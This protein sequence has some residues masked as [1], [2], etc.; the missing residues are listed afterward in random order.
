[1]RC[2]RNVH[3]AA[4]VFHQAATFAHDKQVD[5][6][7]IEYTRPLHR[8]RIIRKTP[9]H[10][11]LQNMENLLASC[12]KMKITPEPVRD[13]AHLQPKVLFSENQ[14]D[15]VN[16]A[17][18]EKTM[19]DVLCRDKPFPI[20]PAVVGLVGAFSLP[21]PPSFSRVIQLGTS[22]KL[23]QGSDKCVLESDLSQLPPDFEADSPVS[24]WE[25]WRRRVLK[26]SG[27]F[28]CSIGTQTSPR[29]RLQ[30]TGVDNWTQTS[31]SE[32]E[33]LTLMHLRMELLQF[34]KAFG[35]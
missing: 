5:P 29:G 11:E 15:I 34:A 6:P 14:D 9:P 7:Q 1:M 17:E 2:I 32:Q 16:L 13:Y 28:G 23:V 26:E 25:V 4:K 10:C 30:N 3:V 35:F 24:R 33:P 18:T 8:L 27:V 20:S 22:T 12:L 19:G 21:T 31:P